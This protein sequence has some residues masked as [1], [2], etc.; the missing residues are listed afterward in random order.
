MAVTLSTIADPLGSKLILDTDS[1]ATAEANVTGGT[2]SFYAVEI[3]NTANTT[4]TYVKIAD[5]SSGTAGTTQNDW[6]FYAPASTKLTYI[7]GTGMAFS[8]ALT[9]WAVTSAAAL[10]G[11]NAAAATSPTSSV[12][13]KILST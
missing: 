6:Q 2:G 1:D 12:P 9:V 13:I 7:V 11:S 3:D 5:A 4:A 10:T 8:T